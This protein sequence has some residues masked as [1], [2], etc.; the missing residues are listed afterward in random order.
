[1]EDFDRWMEHRQ[2]EWRKGHV[3]TKEHG[4]QKGLRRPWLLPTHLW[5]EGLWP[6]IRTGSASPLPEY[7]QST[8]V[9]RHQGSH[10]LKSSWIHCANLYF[11]FRADETG[12]QLLASFLQGHVS[13]EICSVE[14]IDLEYAEEGELAPYPL[15]GEEGGTRG[16]NQT[17]PDLGLLVNGGRGLVLVESKLTEHHFYP[18]SAW[19]HAGSD[20]RA[21]ND[22]P[23]RCNH[24]E[25]VLRDP[26]SQCQQSAWGR[27]YW[28]H[29]VPVAD[30][31]AFA[32]LP[33]CPA[34]RHGY[35]LLRQQALAEGI[36]RSGKYDL[37]VSAVAV[38]ERNEEITT[39]LRRMGMP[40]LEQ[41]GSLFHG[42]TRFAVYTHQQWVAWVREHDVEGQWG[43][44]LLYVRDRYGL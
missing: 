6:G 18:C 39:A 20:R 27:R 30:R 32:V 8:G 21:G 43:D 12:R 1:M 29:L 28:E 34:T 35:Q 10:N 5:E 15:L 23:D 7:L 3:A 4:Q 38:D 41:W 37:V 11:P 13:P 16:A 17:S 33:Y 14:S 40:E 2:I 36:A 24:P 26:T 25:E 44:W 9:Q 22:D 42:Q 19:K 31:D